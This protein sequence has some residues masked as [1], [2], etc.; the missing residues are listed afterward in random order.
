MIVLAAGQGKRMKSD[1]PKVLH[2]LRGRPLVAWVVDAA[3]RAG[4]ERIVAVLGYGREEVERALPAGVESALQAE[5]RGTGHAA[6]CAED[7]LKD[8]AG[9]VV[10]LSGDVP[11]IRAETIR[12]LVARRARD[13][14]AVQVLSAVVKGPH[15]YGRIVRGEGG[16]FRRIVEHKDAS[17]A[18]R[19]IEEFNTGTYAFGPGR[20]FEALRHLKDDN[21]QGE[22]YLTDTV[23]WFA[24][25]GERVGALAAPRADEC[26]GINTP[27]ELAA[28]E[29]AAAG[30]ERE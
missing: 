12:E 19:R 5:Q 13:N 7:Q 28:A 30:R 15:A 11:L 24:A 4:A 6:R 3:R 10:V 8:Y 21:A 2:P 17:E 22:F 14:S 20:L 18:E 16:A 23:A 27:E 26:L 29:R 9:P 1:L 25:R